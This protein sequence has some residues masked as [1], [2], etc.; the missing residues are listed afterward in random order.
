[1]IEWF[2]DLKLGMRLSNVARD[3]GADE[4]IDLDDLRPEM[5]ELA[6][7]PLLAT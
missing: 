3:V 1:M 4:R 6:R 7:H 2:D 5:P